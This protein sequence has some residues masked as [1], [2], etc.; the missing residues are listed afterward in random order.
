MPKFAA[1][2]TTKTA[3]KTMATLINKVTGEHIPV[4]ATTNHPASSYGKAVWVDDKGQAYMQVGLANPYYEVIA[5][6]LNSAEGIGEQLDAARR[7]K[8][9][10]IAQLAEAVGVSEPTIGSLLN[11]KGNVG[12]QTLVDVANY[13]GVQIALINI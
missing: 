4:T 13:I 12:V 5:D 8:R 6:T 10:T 1:E 7:A 9:M 3:M 11:G 2:L